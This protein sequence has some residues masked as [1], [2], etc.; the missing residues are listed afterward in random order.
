MIWTFEK[1]GD[2][3]GARQKC[4]NL[5]RA[6]AAPDRLLSQLPPSRS[7]SL[8]SVSASRNKQKNIPEFSFLYSASVQWINLLVADT[9][10]RLERKNKISE[11]ASRPTEIPD[12]NCKISIRKAGSESTDWSLKDLEA[13]Y[14]SSPEWRKIKDDGVLCVPVEEPRLRRRP[15]PGQSGKVTFPE[16][17]YGK[18]NKIDNYTAAETSCGFLFK[19]DTRMKRGRP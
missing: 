19:T 6:G 15:E 16:H 4:A 7:C 5:T 18:G 9:P 2:F 14:E 13:S 12:E 11:M 10:Q 17:E 3:P 1:K 8:G